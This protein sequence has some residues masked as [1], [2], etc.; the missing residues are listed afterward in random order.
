MYHVR[1]A[2]IRR[3]YRWQNNPQVLR[4]LHYGQQM[5][6]LRD[7]LVE[8]VIESIREKKGTGIAVADLSA[9][10]SASVGK[11]V[12]CSA[13]STTQVA[14][15]ADNIRERLLAETGTK[16]Y[17]YDGYRNSQWIVI[18]YGELFVHVFLPEARNHYK[19]EQLWNDA[20]FTH[21]PDED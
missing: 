13:K 1:S 3:Q 4:V 17:A 7:N 5:K 21:I 10:E 18:D 16:P 20:E 2:A 8:T 11:F 14:A 6:G 12:I 15:I 19:L 9:I